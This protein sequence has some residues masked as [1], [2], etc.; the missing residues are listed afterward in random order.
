MEFASPPHNVEIVV[1]V[2]LVYTIVEAGEYPLL[3]EALTSSYCPRSV[4][5]PDVFWVKPFKHQVEQASS[6]SQN[7]L[8]DGTA[9]PIP[10]LSVGFEESTEDLVLSFLRIREFVA[11]AQE[12]ELTKLPNGNR[13]RFILELTRL[14]IDDFL[15]KALQECRPFPTRYSFEPARC[16]EIASL[17]GLIKGLT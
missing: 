12:Q 10:D 9:I 14:K 3:F 2:N 16:V 11:V 5:R 8:V 13:I 15:E 1:G 6:N 7:A 17:E 4:P